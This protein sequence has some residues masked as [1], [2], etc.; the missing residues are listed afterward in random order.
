[1]NM[2]NNKTNTID[3][4]DVFGCNL[5]RTMKEKNYTI[6]KLA[7]DLDVSPRVVYDW[8]SG[9]KFPRFERAIHISYILKVSLDS[10]VR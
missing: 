3:L 7:E 8:I 6:E 4:M 10:L 9:L 5:K 2:N 1:M